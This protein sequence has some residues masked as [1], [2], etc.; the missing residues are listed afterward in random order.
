MVSG[1]KCSDEQVT[2]YN[3][4][5]I[6][7]KHRCIILKL[8]STNDGL[9]VEHVG[10]R[11]FQIKELENQLPND[12]CRFII[13]DFEYDTDENP[14]R[15][16][17]K[18]ILILWCPDNTPIK[19]RVPFSSTKAEVKSTFVGIQKD[20]QVSDKSQLDFEELRKECM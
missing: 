20:I 14:P 11:D 1:M 17:T 8:N 5:K 2:L 12:D 13:F 10:S 3:E 16:T 18:L 7:K 19:K 15:H 4:L 6:D 9:E